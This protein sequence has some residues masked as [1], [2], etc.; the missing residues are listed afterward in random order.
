MTCHTHPEYLAPA[1]TQNWFARR[2]HGTPPA[3]G[4]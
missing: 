2:Q 1:Y 4:G 3:A